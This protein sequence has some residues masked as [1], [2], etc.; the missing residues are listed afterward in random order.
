MFRDKKFT[1]VLGNNKWLKMRRVEG[2][3]ACDSTD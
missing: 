2:Q 3:P 1:V